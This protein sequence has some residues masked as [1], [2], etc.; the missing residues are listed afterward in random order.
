MDFFETLAAIAP[1]V[2]TAIAIV[3]PAIIS[4]KGMKY[5]MEIKRQERLISQW[6]DVYFDFCSCYVKY[7]ACGYQRNAGEEFGICAYKLSAICDKDG[8]D[9]LIALGQWVSTE[10]PEFMSGHDLDCKLNYC[11]TAIRRA[12]TEPNLPSPKSARGTWFLRLFSHGSGN[13]R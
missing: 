1:H 8:A 10:E 5:D 12:L 2:T 11:S 6:A 3:V 7:A 4:I 13:K 9:A